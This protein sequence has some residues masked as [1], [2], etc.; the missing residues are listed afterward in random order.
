[1]THHSYLALDL[2]LRRSQ[3]PTGQEL[4]D[5]EEGGELD[6]QMPE[7]SQISKNMCVF[8]KTRQVEE[9]HDEYTSI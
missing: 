7:A 9:D 4:N 1:M 6:K 2:P 5:G 8:H 3:E